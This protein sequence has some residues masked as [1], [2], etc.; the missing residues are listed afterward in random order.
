M[1]SAIE[2]RAMVEIRNV[3]GA[4]VIQNTAAMG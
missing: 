4:A 1:I 2:P 3:L